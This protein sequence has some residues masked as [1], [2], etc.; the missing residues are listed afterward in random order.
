MS[1]DLVP[2]HERCRGRRHGTS[3]RYHGLIL[4]V[5]RAP[6]LWVGALFCSKGCSAFWCRQI[7][8]T[9]V[10]WLYTSSDSW[11]FW[12]PVLLSWVVSNKSRAI[13]FYFS[14]MCSNSPDVRSSFCRMLVPGFCLFSLV[15]AVIPLWIC[16]ALGLIASKWIQ[17][18]TNAKLS[19][20]ECESVPPHDVPF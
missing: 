9:R 20:E 5:H 17:S 16:Y 8:G 6:P 12:K 18:R 13:I 1:C 4:T 3:P 2:S 15:G 14:E 7:A 10:P 11:P 19:L